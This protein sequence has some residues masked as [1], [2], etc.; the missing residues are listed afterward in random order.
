MRVA[1]ISQGILFGTAIGILFADRRLVEL[2]FGGLIGAVVL[3]IAG[4]QQPWGSAA[5]I[6]QL[7]GVGL[8]LRCC[9]AV[10]LTTGSIA[11]GMDGFLVGDDRAYFILARAFAHF[12]QGQPEP[13]FDPPYWAGEG[14]LFGAW[15]YLESF[16]F[17]IA[18]PLPLLPIFLNCALGVTSVV[19]TWTLARELFG[20]RAAMLAAALVNFWPSLILW[21]ALNLKDTLALTLI[22]LLFVALTRLHRA[23]APRGLL[24]PILALVLMQ[25]LRGYIFTGLAL[26]L[27]IASW[28]IRRATWRFALLSVVVGG[29]ALALDQTGLGLGPSLIER[30]SVYRSG[31]A[32]GART[33][34]VDVPPIQVKEGTTLVVAGDSPSS[35]TPR[36]VHVSPPTRVVARPGDVL[37][38]GGST[39]TPAP[40][41][42][43]LT[44]AAGQVNLVQSR[45]ER[46]A[47]P[48]VKTI[49][50]LP[51]G[52]TYSLFAPWPW[53]SER[54]LDVLTVPEM[55]TWYACLLAAAL[56]TWSRRH[57]RRLWVPVL[58]IGGL[59]SVFA[60]VE[61][62][63]GTLFR[64][65][66]MV[67]PLVVSLAAPSLLS[68]LDAVRSGR[69]RRSRLAVSR[70]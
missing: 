32:E 7:A 6:V 37:V 21:S 9:L 44:V 61:G 38:V 4:M 18:G 2:A 10:L 47:D 70:S 3:R 28:T 48:I 63:W 45:Q 11:I 13:P 58:F 16:L 25:S 14:Y 8:A 64:H 23:P 52:L 42:A 20:T 19:L 30:S 31:M 49:E 1:A 12:L 56:T 36:I 33:A 5:F 22:L 43:R 67:I 41:D 51:I 59:I 35:G 26:L 60:L 65:R 17:L 55:L 68:W 24:V 66:A 54:A 29:A 57:D 53:L 27:P 50:H 46:T 40:P 39:T 15:V 62:N 69:V 34:F